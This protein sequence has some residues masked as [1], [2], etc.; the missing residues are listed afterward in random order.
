MRFKALDAI[1]NQVGETIETVSL[2]E[3]IQLVNH[4]A[5][6]NKFVWR[7]VN[8]QV[9]YWDIELSD[10]AGRSIYFRLTPHK[11]MPF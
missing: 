2:S 5:W 10:E 8:P 9:D 4:S 6:G 1:G 11:D 3:A 7:E